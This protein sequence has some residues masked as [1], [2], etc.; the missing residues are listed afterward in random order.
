MGLTIVELSERAEVQY[1]DGRYVRLTD[2]TPA[3]RRMNGPGTWRQ[4]E[5]FPSGRFMLVAYC[6]EQAAGWR[7]EWRESH[8][9][10]LLKKIPAIVRSLERAAPKVAQAMRAGREKEAIRK[11]A[12]DAAHARWLAEEDCRR[13]ELARRTSREDL[14]RI[15]SLWSESRTVEI[16]L[17]EIERGLAEADLNDDERRQLLGRLQAARDLVSGSS[18]LQLFAE[19]HLSRD[20]Q[21]GP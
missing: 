3:Q 9:G 14:L 20:L 13:R 11:Q 16:F 19:W 15:I 12:E 17:S 6:P 5:E 7:E 10:E 2:L 1:V 18:A 4:M 21:F 8:Q